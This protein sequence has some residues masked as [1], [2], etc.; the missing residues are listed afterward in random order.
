MKK[1]VAA[2]LAI[3]LAAPLASVA[4][5]AADIPH[6]PIK[7]PPRLSWS[8]AGP[9]G[10]WDKGQ[11]QRGLKVYTEVCSGCHSLNMVAFRNLTDLGYSEDQVKGF[12]ASHQVTDGPN[13]QGEMFKRQGKP[14]DYFPAPFANTEAAAYAN[15]GAAP[16]DFSTIAKARAVESGFPGFVFDIFTMYTTK[17]PDYV[18]A[19]LTGYQD[20]P[21]GMRVP[22][23]GY[24]NPYF[25]SAAF[26]KMPPPL[27]D[28]VVKYDDGTPETVDQYAKDIAAFQMWAAEPHMVERKE[29]GFVVIIFLAIF[30]VL[31][32]Y[33]KKAIYSRLDDH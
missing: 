16:P 14:N 18:H 28:G 31:I 29:T 27:S 17:G 1:L 24:Y 11:L 15:G 2:A 26:L 23:G 21:K 8:F 30:T 13:D 7:D 9:F 6:Y 33:T 32:Y 25:H 10:T 3:G 4:A 12:A 19:L 5:G 22:Q 20:P